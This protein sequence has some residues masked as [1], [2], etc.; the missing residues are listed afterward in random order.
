MFPL[1]RYVS[2]TVILWGATLCCHA[3]CHNFV[4]LMLVRFFLGALEGSVIAGFV[5]ITA[6]WYQRDE[7]ATR[8]AYW[9]MGNAVA[10]LGGGALA[11]GITSGFENRSYP[12]W[13]VLFILGGGI[14][15]FYGIGMLIFFPDSPLDA[16]WLNDHDRHVAI[17]RLRANQQ[18]I[19][20]KV[21]KWP[22]FFEAF[23]D[24][25]VSYPANPESCL[26]I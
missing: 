18:G 10:Q 17:E 22:Q 23:T 8:T 7:Q 12:G 24:P 9:Y 19:G 26:M 1:A 25:R 16:K 3:A 21:F 11:F 13:K 4:G 5:L 14:T 20:S 2:I 6:R 15:I